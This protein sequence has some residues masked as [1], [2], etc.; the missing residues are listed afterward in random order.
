MLHCTTYVPPPAPTVVVLP[1]VM[2]EC[3]AWPASASRSSTSASRSFSSAPEKSTSTSSRAR[4]PQHHRFHSLSAAPRSIILC[5]A[6][7]PPFVFKFLFP[8]RSHLVRVAL[9]PVPL[10]QPTHYLRRKV[11]EGKLRPHFAYYLSALEFASKRSRKCA[12]AL[13]QRK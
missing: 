6:A 10:T 9:S 1:R 13:V 4:S 11:S 7:D 5:C 3:D 12:A 2:F 8:E